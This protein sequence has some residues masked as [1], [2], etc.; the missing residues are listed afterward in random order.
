[1]DGIISSIKVDS[2]WAKIIVNGMLVLREIDIFDIFM[3]FF[4]YYARYICS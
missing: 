3:E 1:M 2:E 4:W